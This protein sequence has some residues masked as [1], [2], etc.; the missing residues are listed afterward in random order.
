MD[1]TKPAN[2]IKQQLALSLKELLLQHPFEKITVKEI[3][4]H[5]GYVRSTFYHHFCDKYKLLEWIVQQELLSP[6][7]SLL[8][9][10]ITSEAI[11]ALFTHLENDRIFYQII[12]HTTG[13]NSF[14][15]ILQT[16]LETMFSKE[17]EQKIPTAKIDVFWKQPGLLAKYYG[18]LLCF[19]ITQ[20]LNTDMCYTAQDVA[21][22][23]TAI[24]QFT[25]HE[26]INI[27]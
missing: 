3:A 23:C 10:Q 26:L 17:F 9:D 5:A 15:Y 22:A 19:M 25:L 8:A 13:Q 27:S 24:T 6:V 11:I 4:E 7:Q 1:M 14:S 2:Q 20:W 21:K 16:N 18:Q 12:N